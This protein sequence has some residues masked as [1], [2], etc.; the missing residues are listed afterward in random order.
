MSAC[1]AA[2]TAS[3]AAGVRMWLSAWT[4]AFWTTPFSAAANG[5][6]RRGS[7]SDVGMIASK[8]KYEPVPQVT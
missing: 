5:S 4:S 6:P 8:W 2:R 7:N 1:P 3:A